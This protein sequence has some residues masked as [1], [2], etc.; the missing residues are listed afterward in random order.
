MALDLPCSDS[1]L[2]KL[3][4]WIW[5][6]QKPAEVVALLS[7]A[8]LGGMAPLAQEL[9]VLALQGTLPAFPAVAVQTS[10]QRSYISTF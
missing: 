5:Q 1:D 10:H 4:C 8:C 7:T 2:W 9:V 3:L 6:L